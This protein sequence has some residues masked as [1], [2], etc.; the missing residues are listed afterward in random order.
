MPLDAADLLP[1]KANDGS[2]MGA[3]R[4]RQAAV[5]HAGQG[6]VTR[7]GRG[8]IYSVRMGKIPWL[9]E[10]ETMRFGNRCPS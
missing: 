6:F 10:V 8:L 2:P 1:T 7:W 4:N 3:S 9:T 5:G